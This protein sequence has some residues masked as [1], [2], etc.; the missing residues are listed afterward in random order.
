MSDDDKYTISGIYADET[1]TGYSN[2]VALEEGESTATLAAREKE[3]EPNPVYSTIMLAVLAGLVLAL[4]ILIAKM[5]VSGRPPREEPY[6]YEGPKA[7]EAQ[8]PED[9]PGPDVKDEGPPVK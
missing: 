9:A 5:A 6:V 8:K 3:D 7:E 1:G 2:G 4:V